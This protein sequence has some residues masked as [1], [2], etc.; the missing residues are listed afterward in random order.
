MPITPLTLPAFPRSKLFVDVKEQ[1]FTREYLDYLIDLFNR[2][3]GASFFI[4][5][6]S[7]LT[8][9]RIVA[10]D[11]DGEAESVTDLT[12]WILGTTGQITVTD[13]GDGTVTLSD[14]PN[15]TRITNAD[16]PYT[17]LSNDRNIFTNT[18]NDPIIM[19]LVVGSKGIYHRIANT[20]SSGN[21]VTLNP[22]GMDLLLGSNSSVKLLDGDVLIIVYEASGPEGWW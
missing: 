22:N 8:A 7:P 10:T 4:P 6:F 3:G 15:T 11:S 17:T 14:A 19:N 18:D 2:V 1:E 13:N 20:G 21:A 5:D 16:S 12:N 9:S